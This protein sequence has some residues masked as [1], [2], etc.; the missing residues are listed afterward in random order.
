MIGHRYGAGGV[1]MAV[2]LAPY[3][4]ETVTKNAALPVATVFGGRRF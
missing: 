1:T 2:S 4:A 3:S